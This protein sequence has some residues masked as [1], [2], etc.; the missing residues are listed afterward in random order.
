MS[1]VSCARSGRNAPSWLHKPK[2]LRNSVRLVGRGKRRIA[3]V[4]AGSGTTPLSDTMN[5]AN[6][7]RFPTSSLR[8]LSLIPAFLHL[9]HTIRNLRKT[10]GVSSACSS[11]SSTIFNIHGSPTK[12]LSVLRQNSSPEEQRPMGAETYLYLPDGSRKVV[13]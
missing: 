1:W 13:R 12:A 11:K 5:P 2:K 6:F 4:L 7:T 8:A 3:S 9:A 10:S